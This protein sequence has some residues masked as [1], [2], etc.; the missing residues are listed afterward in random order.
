[1][2]LPFTIYHVPFAAQRA[3]CALLGFT[4]VEML[5]VLLIMGLFV[6]LVSAIAQPDERSRL[7]IEAERLARLLD[8]AAMESR[9]TGKTL[10][11][12]SDGAGYR[13]WSERPGAGWSEIVDNDLLRPRDLPA[14]TTITSLRVETVRPQ[15]TMRLAFTPYGQTPAFAIE[16]SSGA[17]RYAVVASPIGA[18]R[19]VPGEGASHGV[20]TH[21]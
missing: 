11:W 9:M 8:L 14:H 2:N 15:G 21:H 17:E 18:I 13:F 10:G 1:M 4:L 16:L 3:R 6:G 7:Q 19:A 12:T 5:V 20:A